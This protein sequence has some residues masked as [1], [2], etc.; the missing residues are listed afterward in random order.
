MQVCIFSNKGW[1]ARDDFHLVRRGMPKYLPRSWTI[2]MFVREEML[3]WVSK[4]VFREKNILDLDTLQICPDASL[5][6]EKGLKRVMQSWI[7]ALAKRKMLF[8][9]R[10]WLNPRGRQPTR[11]GDSCLIWIAWSK[12]N[13]KWFR[14]RIKR[15]EDNGSPC[16][17]PRDGQKGVLTTPFHRIEIDEDEIHAMIKSIIGVGKW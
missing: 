1:K 16:L 5:K 15:Y 8:T 7:F 4:E 3:R 17:I 2:G 6:C 11:I 10:I 12:D 14:Q 13:D 9:N